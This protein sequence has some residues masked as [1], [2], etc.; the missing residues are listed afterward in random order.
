MIFEENMLVKELSQIRKW[1]DNRYRVVLI[2]VSIYCQM[3][4]YRAKQKIY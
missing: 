3:I 1:L 2:A 4:K